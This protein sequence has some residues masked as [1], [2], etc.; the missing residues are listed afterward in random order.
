MKVKAIWE[1]DVDVEGLDP[2]QIDIPGMAKD[3]TRCELAYLLRKHDIVADDFE[4]VVDVE[5]REE[6]DMNKKV[7]FVGMQN[8]RMASSHMKS[9][10]G[11]LLMKGI[12]VWRKNPNT[13]AFET[14]NTYVRYVCSGD[15]SDELV[16]LRADA[17]FGS[18][19]DSMTVRMNPEADR[20]QRLGMCTY[21]YI[22]T[23][24]F[25]A[26]KDEDYCKHDVEITKAA[27]KKVLKPKTL[28]PSMLIEVDTGNMDDPDEMLADVFK[29][30]HTITDREVR[31][32]VV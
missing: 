21:E 27:A 16:G 29:Y 25:D 23:V 7:I 14:P 11:E 3:V 5:N 24:E 1:F 4:Y 15:T 26:L 30:V 31:I 8:K 9:I 2:K 13:F 19:Y 32:R 10:I 28:N 20:W 12:S 22:Y 18:I 17:V 6:N